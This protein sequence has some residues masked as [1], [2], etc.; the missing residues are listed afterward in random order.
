MNQQEQ[1]AA[2]GQ[3]FY[4]F[5]YFFAASLNSV[6]FRW[7]YSQITSVLC[8]EAR[9]WS[10]SPI[11]PVFKLNYCLIFCHQ[12]E[13]AVM[14]LSILFLSPVFFFL[15]IFYFLC[16]SAE[17]EL[18]I[19]PV[20]I[21]YIVLLPWKHVTFEMDMGRQQFGARLC[22]SNWKRDRGRYH[23]LFFK[24]LWVLEMFWCESRGWMNFVFS[25]NLFVIPLQ[26]FWSHVCFLGPRLG[27]NKSLQPQLCAT[28]APSLL[29]C[30]FAICDS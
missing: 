24:Y 13:H 18:F 21:C 26:A 29:C 22:V 4:L 25:E 15:N 20:V 14:R 12:W 19:T 5:I 6:K 16:C 9:T 1:T 28:C 17:T 8:R 2:E 3:L 30:H 7:F 11:K 23:S 10:F 27:V